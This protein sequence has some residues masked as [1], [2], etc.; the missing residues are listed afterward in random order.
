VE[1]VVVAEVVELAVAEANEAEALI[2]ALA[3]ALDEELDAEDA[4]DRIAVVDAEVAAEAVAEADA[5]DV[6]VDVAVAALG[7][8]APPT[9]ST[10]PTV[11]AIAAPSCGKGE[12]FLIKRLRLSWARWWGWAKSLASTEVTARKRRT[13]TKSVRERFGGFSNMTVSQRWGSV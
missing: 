13:E 4:T 10:G 12:R 9:F 8:T 3:D 7:S 6:V 2:D 5:A 1:E 11:E